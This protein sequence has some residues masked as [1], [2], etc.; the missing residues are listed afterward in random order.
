MRNIKDFLI[1]SINEN[2][3]VNVILN[4]ERPNAFPL[5]LS[6]RQ[7]CLILQLFSLALQ[8]LVIAVRHEEGI[9]PFKLESKK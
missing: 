8:V 6:T 3:T 7:E 4:C 1:K 5:R 9:N 2:S